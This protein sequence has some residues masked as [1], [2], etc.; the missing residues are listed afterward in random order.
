MEELLL[1]VG[2]GLPMR[3]AGMWAEE[4]LDYLTRYIGVFE[5]SM[6]WKWATFAKLAGVQRMDLIIN[7]PE[8]GLN[9]YLGR[10]KNSA[11]QTAVDAYFGDR[12]WRAAYQASQAQGEPNPHWRLIEFYKS[13]LRALGYKE[14]VRGD[15]VGDE[16]L[17]RNVERRAPL[18]RLL[19]ASK[20]PLGHKFWTAV[21]RRD[22]DGQQLLFRETPLQY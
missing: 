21:T 2:D 3:P 20:S 4:K 17:M 14:V 18:Y 7:Y 1:P 13:R 12:G 16:P 8:G 11:G 22:V 6:R 9:R 19:F 5:T 10:A 15:E